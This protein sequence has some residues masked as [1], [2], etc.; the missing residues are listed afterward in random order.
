MTEEAKIGS[1]LAVDV[2]SN[3]LVTGLYPYY[4][5]R[6]QIPSVIDRAFVRKL[7]VK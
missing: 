3:F 6:G 7:I 1:W 5:I 4:I 2:I